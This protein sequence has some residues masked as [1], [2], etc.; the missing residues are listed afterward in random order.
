MHREEVA[1]AMLI[2]HL[3]VLKEEYKMA[4][5]KLFQNTDTRYIQEYMSLEFLEYARI[6][7]KYKSNMLDYRAKMG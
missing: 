2:S 6:E 3:K 7:F 5:L 4:K 1:E